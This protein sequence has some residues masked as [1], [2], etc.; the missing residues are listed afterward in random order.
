MWTGSVSF[1]KIEM[2]PLALFPLLPLLSFTFIQAEVMLAYKFRT[3]EAKVLYGNQKGD[4]SVHK[5]P[6]VK[7]CGTDH[8]K[9]ND[10]SAYEK[11]IKDLKL[12]PD[13]E[14]EAL[15]LQPADFALRRRLQPQ[16]RQLRRKTRPKVRGTR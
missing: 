3:H 15:A 14:P 7:Q 5:A 2:K 1:Y 9:G 6:A 11:C 10:R 4:E 13:F 12:P 8:L 16:T